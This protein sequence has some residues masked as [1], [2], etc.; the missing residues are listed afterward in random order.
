MS[1]HDGKFDRVYV[2][3]HAGMVGSAIVRRMKAL[4]L[5]EPITATRA[6]LDLREQADVRAFLEQK[7]PSAIIVAATSI[8]MMPVDSSGSKKPAD[9]PT[10]T[11]LPIHWRSR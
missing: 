10:A 5:P 3:G 11:Q 2:A 1:T 8:S 4:G 7:R 9:R 6:E